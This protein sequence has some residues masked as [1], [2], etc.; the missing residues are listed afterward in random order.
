MSKSRSCEELLYDLSYSL[1]SPEAEYFNSLINEEKYSQAKKVLSKEGLSNDEVEIIITFYK[2]KISRKYNMK[3][4]TLEEFNKLYPFG[5][6][7]K[8]VNIVVNYKGSIYSTY[9]HYPV[10]S[11]IK[12]WTLYCNNEFILLSQIQ[13]IWIMEEVI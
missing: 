6:I 13:Q 10:S 3:D 4:V 12:E 1:S 11:K 8:K 7:Y 5:D 9:L 2:K